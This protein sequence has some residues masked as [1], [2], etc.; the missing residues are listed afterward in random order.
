MLR[1][2]HTQESKQTTNPTDAFGNIRDSK[3]TDNLLSERQRLS[4]VVPLLLAST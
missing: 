1:K 3:A 4:S 2:N